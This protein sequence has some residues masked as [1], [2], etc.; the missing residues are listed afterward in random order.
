MNKIGWLRLFF[1][2]SL[3]LG[4]SEV[5]YA[6]NA[7]AEEMIQL[8][9]LSATYKANFH[10]VTYNSEGKLLQRSQGRVLIARPG[11]FRWEIISPNP[12]VL[13]TDGK[14]L[15]IYNVDLSEATERALTPEAPVNPAIL[16]SGT[17]SD[18]TR[19]FQISR[20]LSP[21]GTTFLLQPYSGEASFRWLQLHFESRQL[22]QMK[23]MNDLNELSI[24]NFNH[25]QTN[26]PLPSQ[27]F[28]FTPPPDVDVLPSGV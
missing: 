21:T 18:L 14:T 7:A 12:Q 4:V 23:V 16:L 6:E 26:I 11:G 9:Q 25:V 20:L 1:F 17:V 22:V 3:L 27:W 2:L 15:W 13:I 10:Q 24:F 28:R 19:D 5:I 8:L